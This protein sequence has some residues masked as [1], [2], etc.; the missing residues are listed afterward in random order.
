[1]NYT[2]I[3]GASKGIG[4]AFAFECAARGMNLILVARSANLLTELAEQ[5]SKKNILVQAY[6]AD[7]LDHAVHKKIF[8]WVKENGW[9]VNMLINNAGTGLY[10]RFDEQ[11]LEKHLDVMRLN[12]DAMVKMAYEFLHHTDASQRR[13]ILN[14]V[15]LGAY[16]PV[17]YVTIYSATKSFMLFFS[18]GL[19]HELLKK[20]VHVTALCPGGVETDFLAL[21]GL[22]NVAKKNA[23]FMVKPEEVVKPGLDGVL[24]NKAVVIPGILNK[25]SAFLAWLFPYSMVVPAAAKVYEPDL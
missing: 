19:R 18:L 8:A 6:T 1:M 21:A 15:S 20:Q 16:Q 7:L 12:M 2:L 13:Y 22:E 25:F 5:L 23:R 14:T 10:G 11:P 4:R 9:N 3:T 17:P 24:R